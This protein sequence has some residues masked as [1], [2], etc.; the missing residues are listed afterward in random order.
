MIVTARKILA[1]IIMLAAFGLT[2]GGAVAIDAS[3]VPGGKKTRLG[4]YLTPKEAFDL[5]QKS[6]GKSL[7]IDVRTAPEVEFLGTAA[8]VD[9]HVP[10]EFIDTKK[11]NDKKNE[12]VMTVNKRFVDDVVARVKK[13]GLSKNDPI[14]LM[15]RS[16]SRS[17]RSANLLAAAGFTKVYNQIEGYEGD[18][19]GSG[20]KK[21]QRAVNGWKNA[22]LPWTYKMKKDVM[23]LQK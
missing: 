6:P 7:F 18:K 5:K 10:Y 22:G 4:L 13:A 20:P 3:K 21:G 2:A 23:Y 9:A 19:A 11:W 14:I 16:G 1:P 15:C 12:Y 17:A 8:N